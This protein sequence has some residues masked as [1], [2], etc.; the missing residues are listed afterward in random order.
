ME[1]KIIDNEKNAHRAV[2]FLSSK[3]AF[4]LELNDFRKNA[5]EEAV[6]NSLSDKHRRYWY[7]EN[8][9]GQIIGAIGITEN[10]RKNGGYYLDYFA[11]HKDYRRKGI[12]S[13]LLKIA[14]EFVSELKGRFIFIDTG[15]T[16][17]FEPARKFYENNG[18]VA[19][20][21]IPEY[22]EKG[23]G[24]IDYYKKFD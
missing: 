15:D 23:D 5:R 18:Y 8:E 19:V 14:G 21:H 24:R 4:E 20:S 7:I 9:N 17:L 2:N 3:D 12:G 1:I 13:K 22:Y 10:E 16:Q 11:V 6:M